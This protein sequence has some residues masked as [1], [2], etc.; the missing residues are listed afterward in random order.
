VGALRAAGHRVSLLAP[1]TPGGALVGPGPGEVERVLPWE[2]AAVA[3]LLGSP[4]DVDPEASRMLAAF[5]ALVAFTASDGLVQ[6]LRAAAPRARVITRSPIPP[7][8]RHHA[9]R[10]LAEAVNPLGA[11][12]SL[13]PPLLQ[14]TGAE[15]AAARPYLDGLGPGFLAVHPGSGSPR[16]NWPPERFAALVDTL[17]VRRGRPWLLVEGPADH[18]AVALLGG[19]PRAIVARDLPARALGAILARAGAYVGND[20]GVSHLAAAW[21]APTVALFGPT[22][23]VLWSPIGPRVTV[24][25][26]RDA[27]M[28]GLDVTAVEE[29]VT[30]A[31]GKSV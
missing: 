5:D 1:S 28:A 22:D 24:V 17:A 27:T 13:L 30:A 19:R 11:D 20:S 3:R 6:G 25:R 23:P 21:G 10:W 2:S 18:E 12:P 16:K 9:A 29:A 4:R 26:S 31:A 15:S 14:A 8:A 7:A